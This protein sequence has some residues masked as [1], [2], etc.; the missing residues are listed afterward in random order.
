MGRT[1]FEKLYSLAYSHHLHSRKTCRMERPNMIDE[2][3]EEIH[4]ARR[5]IAEECDHDF[6]KLLA[7]YKRMQEE[8]PER[9]VSKVPKSDSDS[10]QT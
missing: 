8:H 1:D 2:I 9:Y 3:I 4:E 7:R 10:P 5:K 6:N